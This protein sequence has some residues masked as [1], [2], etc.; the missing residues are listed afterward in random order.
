MYLF[1]QTPKP[2][3]PLMDRILGK[4][5]VEA[6]ARSAIRNK[7]FIT[8]D[9]DKILPDQMAVPGRDVA[10]AMAVNFVGHAVKWMPRGASADILGI[11][12]IVKDDGPYFINAL[13][14][15]K[16]AAVEI[17]PLLIKA[18]MSKAI[19]SLI[20]TTKCKFCSY[21][22]TDVAPYDGFYMPCSSCGKQ[23]YVGPLNK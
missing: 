8:Y 23:I 6:I 20:F 1:D 19:V 16:R 13:G 11:I 5:G 4:K 14:V 2:G 10:I 21:V 9:G 22:M 7:T 12:F 17:A 18:A 3:K 15:L